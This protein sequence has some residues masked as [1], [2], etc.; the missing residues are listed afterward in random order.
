MSNKPSITIGFSTNNLLQ[1]IPDID[2]YGAFIGT[3]FQSA[4][5]NKVF[6]VNSLIEAESQGI[7]AIDEPTAHRHIKE[8]YTELGG[9]QLIYVLLVANTVTMAQMLD[10][11]V[12]DKADKII[13]AGNGR[14]ATLAV[15]RTPPPNYVAGADYIDADVPA[16]VTAAKSFCQ[17]QNSKLRFLR[18]LIEGR[19]NNESSTNIYE[20]NKASNGY[21]G[22]VAGGTLNDKSASVGVALARKCKYAC[23]IKIGKVENGSLSINTAYIGTKVLNESSQ[24]VIPAIA[25]VRGTVTATC[26]AIGAD[27]DYVYIYHQSKAGFIF[28]GGY[29]KLNTDTTIAAVA[30]GLKN[31]INT[32]TATHGYSAVSA[33]GVITITLPVD[34]GDTQNGTSLYVGVNGTIAFTKTAV[35]GGVTAKPESLFTIDDLHNKGYITYLTYPTTA[36]IFFGIDNMASDDD[37]KL[38]VR[39]GVADA[40]AKIAAA[41]YVKELE[42][43]ADTED[44]GEIKAIESEYLTTKIEQTVKNN[45]GERITNFFAFITPGINLIETSKLGMKLRIQ[46][47]GYKTFIEVDLGFTSTAIN[48]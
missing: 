20:P 47:K 2:G 16:A 48:N 45:M 5:L 24:L 9:N 13:R 14:I 28:L 4:N 32:N 39:G 21:V 27:N 46:P 33:A 30:L 35:T 26:T 17:L 34:S 40:C 29:S 38:L 11:T 23:H 8:F 1:S 18:I 25:E 15:F 3:G 37:F 12:I 42:G 19:I 7:T 22:V 31:A 36:G 6:I 41:V 43:E 44:N 10:S